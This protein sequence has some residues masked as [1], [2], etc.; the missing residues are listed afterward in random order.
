[1][2]AARPAAPRPVRIDR[3]TFLRDIWDLQPGEHVALIG[4]TGLGKTQ[5]GLE[6]L[7]VG[8]EHHPQQNGVV[9]AMKPQRRKGWRNRRQTGDATLSRLV[10]A[11]GAKIVR[12]WPPP[13]WA[14]RPASYWVL[15]P[16]H[17]FD[18]ALD[19][20]NHHR[21]FR[22]ALL[23]CYRDGGWW[24]FADET[25]SLSTELGL[26]D[27]LITVWTKGRSMETGLVAATQKPSHVPLW[28]YSMS[29]HLFLWNDPDLRARQRF[30]EISGFDADTI[31]RETAALEGF[32]CLYLHPRDKTMCIVTSV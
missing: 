24:V 9:F 30:A 18:P 12:S 26:K 29:S 14:A 32:D 5:L 15:W 31:K 23:R 19:T 1:M 17:D 22:D 3:E 20:P 10:R 4:P 25:Y 8:L 16:K 7:R 28:M 13:A 27:E 11:H 21:I 6:L 2:S